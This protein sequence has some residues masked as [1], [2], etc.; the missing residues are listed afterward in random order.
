MGFTNWNH[1]AIPP[2]PPYYLIRALPHPL[3]FVVVGLL[4]LRAIS[5]PHTITSSEWLQLKCFVQWA[6]L[7]VVQ[8]LQSSFEVLTLSQKS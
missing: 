8:A 3:Y 1:I 4:P 2:V 5:Q 7:L 6:G